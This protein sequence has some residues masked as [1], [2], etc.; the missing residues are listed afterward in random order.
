MFGL[1][2]IMKQKLPHQQVPPTLPPSSS[3]KFLLIFNHWWLLSNFLWWNE[4][5]CWFRCHLDLLT[6]YSSCWM[7]WAFQFCVLIMFLHYIGYICWL[8]AMRCV[9]TIILFQNVFLHSNWIWWIIWH[10]IAYVNSFYVMFYWF[11]LQSNKC[12]YLLLFRWI[13]VFSCLRG[14]VFLR[15][16]MARFHYD[17]LAEA[18]PRWEKNDEN[19]TFQFEQK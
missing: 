14:G 6:D 13:I 18:E 5:V 7:C 17:F 10:L 9:L 1:F 4:A 16:E 8:V 19:E 11:S 3:N 15:T 2:L 12:V